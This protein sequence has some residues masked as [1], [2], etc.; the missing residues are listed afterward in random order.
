M[1]SRNSPGS[2]LLAGAITILTALFLYAAFRNSPLSQPPA[3]DPNSLPPVG[4]A[5]AWDGAY[6]TLVVK[7][8]PAGAGQGAIERNIPTLR[9]LAPVN[10]FE[11]DLHLGLFI[12]RQTD[13]FVQDSIPLALTRTYRPWDAAVHAFGIGGNHPYDIC[14]TGT[15]N[16]YTY[17]DLTL[18]DGRPIHYPRISPGTSYTDAVY[19]HDQTSSEFYNSQ[20]AWNGDGWTLQFSD[21][22]QVIFPEAY[23]AR[24]FAQGAPTAMTNGAGRKVTFRRDSSRNLET[25]T[26]PPDTLS[27]SATMAPPAWWKPRSDDGSVRRYT[28]D[29]KG[30]LQTVSDGSRTLYEFAYEPL[31]KQ[32]GFDPYV[33]TSIRDGEG[34][35]LLRNRYADG[36]HVSEQRLAGGQVFRYQYIYDGASKVKDAIVTMP[37]GK[38][39]RVSF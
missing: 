37:D 28:Y 30:H 7:M 5:P 36:G 12:L 8:D 15:R 18:E 34:R 38:T 21:G 3:P 14:P 2:M 6:P 35:E 19:R 24:N 10:Q 17:L 32:S 22:S 1:A 16:P 39:T 33:M 23:S 20:I 29:P 11:V 26:S 4:P 13:L 31:I 27:A 9:H 25:L